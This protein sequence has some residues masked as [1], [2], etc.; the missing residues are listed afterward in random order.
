MTKKQIDLPEFCLTCKHSKFRYEDS[1]YMCRCRVN[2]AIN[3]PHFSGP[4]FYSETLSQVSDFENVVSVRLD[5]YTGQDFIDMG[6]SQ[7]G[8]QYM[9]RKFPACEHYARGSRLGEPKRQHTLDGKKM[10]RDR[11]GLERSHSAR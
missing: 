4:A 2:P 8:V 5:N 10:P 7:R 9:A 1:F 3:I 11:S 6:L